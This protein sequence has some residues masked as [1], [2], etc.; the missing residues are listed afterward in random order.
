MPMD[1]PGMWDLFFAFWG[2]LS[3]WAVIEGFK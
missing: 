3:A 2:V 1:A